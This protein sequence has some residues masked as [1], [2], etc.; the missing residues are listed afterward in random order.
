MTLRIFGFSMMILLPDALDIFQ[1]DFPLNEI[2]VW[3]NRFYYGVLFA[4]E[5]C[6]ES[7][8]CSA[9]IFTIFEQ[10]KSCLINY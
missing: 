4:I 1:G 5:V 3:T 8:I 2:K 6:F 7:V 10:P 9:C